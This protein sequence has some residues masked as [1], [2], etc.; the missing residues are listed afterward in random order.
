MK[1]YK[2]FLLKSPYASNRKGRKQQREDRQNNCEMP[3]YRLPHVIA[4]SEFKH[5]ENIL[6][7]EITREEYLT[8]V[9][10]WF[11]SNSSYYAN[12]LKY[13][14]ELHIEWMHDAYKFNLFGEDAEEVKSRLESYKSEIIQFL[15]NNR[16]ILNISEIERQCDFSRDTLNKALQRISEGNQK[17]FRQ[18]DKLVPVYLRL[19]SSDCL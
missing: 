19:V 7:E 9:V 1:Y 11:K 15:L 14:S 18:L 10:S 5:K 2:T 16:D 3:Y 4:Y 13:A 17:S 12:M 6:I 8:F